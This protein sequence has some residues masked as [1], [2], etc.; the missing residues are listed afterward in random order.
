MKVAHALTNQKERVSQGKGFSLVVTISM[1][2]LLSIL[3]VGLIS[4]STATLRASQATDIEA[5]ARSNARLAALMAIGQLQVLAGP[6]TRVT[7]SSK[8]IS[9]NSVEAT[10]VWRSWEGSTHDRSGM[11]ISPDYDLK[12]QT[13]D[14]TADV[15]SD[16]SGRF[17][18]WLTSTAEEESESVGSVPGAS[19]T[20]SSD[21]VKMV[22]SGTVDTGEQVYLE[23]T[24]INSEEGDPTGAL[25]WWT[26]GENTKAY[27][28]V[29]AEQQ[30]NS[31]SDWQE[32]LRGNLT[33]DGAVFGFDELDELTSE[34]TIIPT[35][36]SLSLIGNSRSL[37]DQ[38]YDLT[39][40]SRGLMTNVNTGG[41]RKDLNSFSEFFDS[42]P[43]SRLPLFAA[44]PGSNL[45]F[46]KATSS[47][48]PRN[49]LMYHWADYPGSAGAAVWRQTPRVS[50]WTAL[51]NY[52]VKYR[53][54]TSSSS[55][56]LTMDPVIT[57]STGGNRFDTYERLRLYPQVAKMQWVFSAGARNLGRSYNPGIVVTPIITLINPFNVGIS[58]SDYQITMD[59]VF[60]LRV[61]YTVGRRLYSNINLH[62][63]VQD[64]I[65]LDIGNVNLG[66][67][68]SMVYSLEDNDT[69]TNLNDGGGVLDL[70]PGYRPNGGALFFELNVLPDSQGNLVNMGAITSSGTTTFTINSIEFADSGSDRV[71][72]QNDGDAVSI[73]FGTRMNGVGNVNLI[74]LLF[75]EDDIG[76]RSVLDTIYPPISERISFSLADIAGEGNTPFAT[77][78]L[79]LRGVAPP[80]LDERFDLIRTK[81]FLQ[82]NPL[83][84]YS[85][86]GSAATSV[87]N[88]AGSGTA[89]PVNAAYDFVIDQAQSWNDDSV[90]VDEGP[91]NSAYLYS[92]NRP[93]DGITRAVVTEVPIRPLQ[94]LA[95][96]QNFNVRGGN[97]FPP[98]QLH[99]IGNS[100]AH[101]IFA[102]DQLTIPTSGQFPDLTNDDSFLLNHL[103]FDDWFMSSIAPDLRDFSARENRDIEQVMIDFLEQEED[104][105]NRFYRPSPSALEE[106]ADE[107]ASK[108]L[109]G[110]T[111]GETGL[112]PFESIG[113]LLEVEGMFNINS[114]SVE[115]WEAVLRRT[116]DIE[117]PVFSSNG[118]VS[119]APSEDSV[120]LRTLIANDTV[121]TG[122]SIIGA[123]SG[124]E[125]LVGGFA[126]L[127][128][129]QIRDLAVAIVDEVRTRGPFLSLSEFVN[130]QL[131]RNTSLAMSGAI[132]RAIQVADLNSALEA[133]GLQVT[134]VPPG[135]PD[136]KFPEAAMGSTLYGMP[137]WLRQADVLRPLAPIMSARDD[138]FTIRS[139][140]DARDSSGNIVARAW[141]ELTVQRR[142]DYVYPSDEPEINA[143]SDDLSAEVN[144]RF[145]RKFELVSFRWLNEEE[146]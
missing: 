91:D 47:A 19:S 69:T 138:T 137:G 79:I 33:P 95:D 66:P 81:G 8:L 98:F 141:C 146:V 116:R 20:A 142:A 59:R 143:F 52:M 30:A 70:A 107:V 68:E 4:L 26:T 72:F 34:D 60:P 80:P 124:N 54:L 53:D 15:D 36:N 41:F 104:L 27:L 132:E 144:R 99:L 82:A 17:L 32:R 16:S 57:S 75:E 90:S 29:T 118:S 11:P 46:N 61:S 23:P 38:F 18:G 105:P 145:G 14:P 62:R 119:T 130:R 44:N 65:R 88:I 111:D 39:T 1:V 125:A 78:S 42:L 84:T 55:G 102:P 113:S 9:E 31:V 48:R 128:D 76:G 134:E 56:N 133:T 71:D 63:I 126:A 109:S 106:E 35:R 112:F 136:Y 85:E 101:P 13:G 96:L 25:A 74:S 58:V 140:G 87:D 7:A 108:Y 28:N 92:G 127:N 67:G 89:H 50:A 12:N 10:G 93:S 123:G 110:A 24:L 117:V 97:Q 49:A 37:G 115:A 94:S 3:A 139:Y 64:R 131:S 51:A 22:G 45:F 73:R 120:F 86:T 83:Q 2:I 6:D 122:Q 114:V 121:R 21:G 100:H 129:S 103:L 40:F 135:N 5:Q 77:T 43:N